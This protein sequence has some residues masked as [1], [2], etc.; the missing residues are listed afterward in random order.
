MSADLTVVILTHNE[1]R[2]IARA[3]ASLIGIARAI[4]VIDSGSSDATCAIAT[5]AGAK[6]LSHPFTTHARQFN[7]GLD[8]A[9]IATAWVMRLDADEVLEP[10]LAAELE[11]MLPNLAVTVTGVEI[12]RK[13]IFMGRWI[14][15]G[16]RFPL[17]LLRVWRTGRARIEDRWMDEHVVLDGGATVRARG[18]FADENLHDLTFFTRKHNDYATRE[19]IDVLMHRYD[20]IASS[21]YKPMA[22]SRQAAVKRW[23][24]V[25]AYNRVPFWLSTLAYFL[26]RFIVQGGFRDGLEGLI[27]HVLQGFWYRFLVGAKV[28]EFDRAIRGARTPGERA[29]A[30]SIASGHVIVA[31]VPPAPALVAG[32][33]R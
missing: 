26:F 12:E 14:R 19:A 28:V 11:T 5:S 22:L 16:G 8:H 29:D 7:W 13:H 20:L 10:A 6:V 24:K 9:E 1:E 15:H 25:H 2:H 17:R 31:P 32:L 4:V 18:R 30:L 21:P 33:P 23:V 3:I 27:Y